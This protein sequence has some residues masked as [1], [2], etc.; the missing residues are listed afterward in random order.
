MPDIEH[1]KDREQ[2]FVKHTLI[3]KYLVSFAFKIFSKWDEIIY[4]DAFAGP[5]GV[6]TKECADS[7]FGIAIAQM[8]EVRTSEV[9][10]SK[11][12][13]RAPRLIAH[14]VEKDKTAFSRLEEYVNSDVADGIELHGYNDRFEDVIDDISHQVHQR[15]GHFIFV[16]LDP[17]G[18]KGMAMQKVQSLLP[19]RSSEILVNVMTSFISRFIEKE[20]CQ[21]SYREFFGR[22]GVSEIV[23]EA[24]SEEKIDVVVREYCRSLRDICGFKYV[25]SCVVLDEKKDAVKYFMVF[26]TNSLDGLKV[27]KDAEA[28]AAKIQDQVKKE[29]K[30][31]ESPEFNFDQVLPS[32]SLREK[33][34]SR[35]HARIDDYLSKH[36]DVLYDDLFGIAMAMPLITKEEFHAYLESNPKIVVKMAPSKGGGKR[37]ALGLNKGDRIF[38]QT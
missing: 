19:K 27:F 10:L 21:D 35:T 25:S 13:G 12:S 6:N 7:S 37:K 23:A 28:I 36:K 4:I 29:L 20:A 33:Y 24:P 30:S 31:P 8:K 15:K 17:K 22:D 2:G 16:L 5:W 1:Y 11:H 18:W 34:R 38:L 14:L 32:Y 9:I 26:G 3:E